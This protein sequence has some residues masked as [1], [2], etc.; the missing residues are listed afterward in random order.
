MRAE[1][2]ESSGRQLG[3]KRRNHADPSTQSIQSVLGNKWE[4]SGDKWETRLKLCEQRIQ[5]VVGDGWETSAK[6]R[7]PNYSDFSEY[8]DKPEIMRA[9]NGEC[10]GRQLGNK[11]EIMQT[12]ALRDP[13]CTGTQV[14]D[15]W[16]FFGE[17]LAIMRA[18][19]QNVVGDNWERSGRQVRN[20]AGPST[21]STQNVL[22]D[23]WR[24]ASNHGVRECRV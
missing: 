5:S 8:T 2:P 15:K 7:G 12:K 18:E 23:K 24:Q 20:H 21:Q 11:R 9:E 19:I 17:K 6:P 1:N 14:G 22:G 13:K 4:T 3:G 10:S 16:I